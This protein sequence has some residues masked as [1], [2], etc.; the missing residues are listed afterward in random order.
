[1]PEPEYTH[2][3]RVAFGHTS[4]LSVDVDSSPEVEFTDPSLNNSQKEAIR[5]ALASNDIILIHGPPGTGK[6]HTLIEL[7]IQMVRRRLRVLV[8]GP[9]NVSVD[10][11]VER[12]APN[13]VPVVRI[14]HPARL[15]PS[16]LEHSLEVLT[17]TSEAAGIVKDVRAEIDQKQASI[18]KTRTGRERRAIFDDLKDLRREYEKGSPNVWI[19]WF[20]KVALFLRRCTVL[21]AIN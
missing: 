19:I 4:P 7:I 10:N 1:M 5:F 18:R 21:V 13:K 9:S 8:C 17:H 3:M 15:L 6:T 16:V 2:F 11:I 12:L 20:E 14:G